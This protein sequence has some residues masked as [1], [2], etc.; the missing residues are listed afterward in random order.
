LKSGRWDLIV[1]THFLPAEIVAALRRQGA[2]KVPQATV[3]TDIDAHR[4]WAQS[5]CERYF[6]ASEEAALALRRWGAPLDRISVTGIPIDPV[7]SRLPSRR[8]SLAE[9]GL[10]GNRPVVLQLSGGSGLGPIEEAYDALLRV[11]T[12]IDLV[13]VAGR[14]REARYKLLRRMVPSRHRARVLGFTDRMHELMRAA[15]LIVSKPGGLTVSEAL[16]C[17]TPMAIFN[18]IPGQESRNGDFLLE[19]GAAIKV[20]AAAALSGKVTALLE[21]SIKLARL[22]ENAVK[23]GR[24]VA[25]FDVAREACAL[26]RGRR[27]GVPA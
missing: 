8:A 24:P 22:R 3:V 23:L 20:N 7:F 2:L 21:D 15:D 16:A 4:F 27:A 5:P 13:V 26:A 1:N 25:A 12:P 9:H 10:M 18:P 11:E 17:G 14:N 19:N 6:V